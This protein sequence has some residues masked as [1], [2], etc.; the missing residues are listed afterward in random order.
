MQD[1]VLSRIVELTTTDF[2]WR[3]HAVNRIAS[4]RTSN[5][6]GTIRAFAQVHVDSDCTNDMVFPGEEYDMVYRWLQDN[7][8]GLMGSWVHPSAVMPSTRLWAAITV[9]RAD[10]EH[11]VAEFIRTWRVDIWHF[12]RQTTS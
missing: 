6:G 2:L 10:W 7:R 1:L 5:V 8:R 11:E 4:G 12:Y 3:Y 9:Y